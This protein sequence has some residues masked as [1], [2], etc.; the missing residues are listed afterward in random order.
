MRY[1][2]DEPRTMA[3]ERVFGRMHQ[4][5]GDSRHSMLAVVLAVSVFIGTG[6]LGFWQATTPTRVKDQLELGV[7][8]ITDVDTYVATAVPVLRQET[9]ANSQATIDLTTFPIAIAVTRQELLDLPDPALRDL[10]LERAA[11]IVYVEGLS[12]FDRTGNQSISMLSSEWFLERTLGLLTGDWHQRAGV[13]AAL[14]FAAA[15]VAGVLIFVQRGTVVGLRTCG[16]AT[17][18]GALP[19]FVFMA[20]GAYWFGH[21]GGGDAFVRAIAAILETFYL[22][23]RRDYLVVATLGA[24]LVL[25]SYT[26]PL[27]D[28][29]VTRPASRQAER[30]EMREYAGQARYPAGADGFEDEPVFTRDSTDTPR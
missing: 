1:D 26:L 28:R 6:A 12:A 30:P 27:G 19:G 25:L 13:T 18:A 22:V 29:L 17:V 8:E 5:S 4:L 20:A 7:A 14:A 2:P 21:T 11:S 23:P 15:A 9:V 24:F 10:I 16:F 3:R